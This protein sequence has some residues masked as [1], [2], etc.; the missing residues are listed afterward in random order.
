MIMKFQFEDKQVIRQSRI[1]LG[2]EKNSGIFYI[3]CPFITSNRLVDYEKYFKLTPD[4]YALF[5]MD[6]AAAEAFSAKCTLGQMDDRLL[7]P[8]SP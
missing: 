5:L 2:V 6:V 8:V 7:Y 3:S 1:S 4:E